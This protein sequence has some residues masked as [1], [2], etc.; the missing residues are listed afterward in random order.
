G[1]NVQRMARDDNTR[2]R[3]TTW[4]GVRVP[5][6]TVEARG[7]YELDDGVLMKWDPIPAEF[8]DAVERGELE[9]FVYP[10][11]EEE[12]AE[13]DEAAPLHEAYLAVR[14]LDLADDDAIL[15]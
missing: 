15:D 10:I 5:A 6:P 2:F 12:L 8:R 14:D 9:S 13:L 1:G 11:P 4:P 7:R 3:I